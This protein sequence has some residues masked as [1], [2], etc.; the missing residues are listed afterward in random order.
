[1]TPKLFILLIIAI[2]ISVVSVLQLTI[3]FI[4]WE[5]STPIAIGAM[6]LSLLVILGIDSYIR[7]RVKE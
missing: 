6:L 5:Y 3:G 7:S 2:L 1:M 4:K